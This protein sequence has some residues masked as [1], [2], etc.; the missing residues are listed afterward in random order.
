MGRWLYV[1]STTRASST[2]AVAAARRSTPATEDCPAGKRSEPAVLPALPP[3]SGPWPA[4]APA[5]PSPCCSRAI[6]ASRGSGAGRPRAGPGLPAPRRPGPAA[7]P[8]CGWIQALPAQDR[9]LFPGSRRII[10]GQDLEL[11]LRGEV[12]RA[13]ARAPPDLG[14]PPSS[15]T[16][17]ASAVTGPRSSGHSHLRGVSIPA[18]GE[19]VITEGRVPHAAWQRGLAPIR[20]WFRRCWACHRCHD[21]GPVWPH[22]R[23]QLVAGRPAHRGHKRGI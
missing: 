20:K 4:P 19:S 21:D 13:P 12:R 15:A 1:G 5:G 16:R 2:L 7:I 9:A 11:V 6:C 22:G 17:P 18:L 14:V 3:R 23:C 8:R 10:G